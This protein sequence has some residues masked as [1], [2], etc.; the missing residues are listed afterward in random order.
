MSDYNSSK[1]VISGNYPQRVSKDGG[2]AGF[3]RV[4]QFLTPERLQNEFLFGV[5][6]KSA[7]TGQTMTPDTMKSIIERAAAYVEM[8]CKIDVFKTAREVRLDYDRTKFTQGWSQLNLG[9]SNVRSV[10]EWSIRGQNSA[11]SLNGA[12]AG[13]GQGSVLFNLPLEWIDLS[14][15]HKGLIHLAPL[16]TTFTGQSLVGGAAAT[17]PYAPLFMTLSKLTFIPGYWYVRFTTGFDD[18]A[19]PKP[20][21]DLIGTVAAMEILSMLGPTNKYNSKSIGIDG[22]SQALSGPGP[23]V[24]ALRLQDLEK[25][26]IEL[27]ETVKKYFGGG[28][29][30]SNI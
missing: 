26:K 9:H 5:P 13:S 22:A 6:L 1:P 19:I 17:G 8:K 7:I 2:A 25:K 12:P 18:G 16:Q 3:T 4:E 15:A 24:F 10:E 29:Y 28:I 23:Q 30:M 20:I 27:T 14:M 11:Y 21:N